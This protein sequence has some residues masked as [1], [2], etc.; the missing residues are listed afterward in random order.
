M[1][2]YLIDFNIYS[3]SANLVDT[4]HTVLIKI[5][6]SKHCGLLEHELAI[7]DQLCGLPGIT[8][9]I[10][11]GTEFEQDVMI[12]EDLGPTLDNRTF[13]EH[14]HPHSYIYSNIRPQNILVGPV[15]PGQQTNELC[16]FDFSLAQLY[17]DP[18]TYSHVPFLSG[19]PLSTIL[20]FALLNHHLG[21]QL[22]H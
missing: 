10:W 16:L 22:S 3:E 19:R 17:R 14:I 9:L 15:L 2:T 11:L 4:G 18:Q 6:Q 8:G 12:F 5:G 13:L 21:N 20:P 1:W 7:L